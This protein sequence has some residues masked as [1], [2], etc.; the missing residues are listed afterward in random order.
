MNIV[1]FLQVCGFGC[2]ILVLLFVVFFGVMVLV[3]VLC[4]FGWQL[5]GYCNVGQLLKLLVDL[6][7]QVLILVNGQVYLWN[8]EICIWCLLVVLVGVCDVQC[9]ILLQG[10]GKVWQLF[11]YNVDNVEILWLGM[12]LVL[13]V[14]LFVLW[15]LVLLLVLC[16]VLLG[17]DDLVGL[18]VYVIDLNGFV[19]MCY[20][21]GFDFGGLCKDMVMLLKLK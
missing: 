10:L 3:V 5:I 21:L 15:L 20:V 18:L 9:V 6:C 16:V 13:I 1:M 11:G 19:I 14:L 4:F 2:W 8:F 7:Q 12:L 17:V